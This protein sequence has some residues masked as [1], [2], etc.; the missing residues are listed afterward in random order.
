MSWM[1]LMSLIIFAECATI[2][3][4]EDDAF[5][6]IQPLSED[7]VS[8]QIRDYWVE[9]GKE[10][11]DRITTDSRVPP[12]KLAKNVII[13]V[14]DGMGATTT[15]A[16]RIYKGQRSKELS[17]EEFLLSFD[18][19]PN[20]ALAKTYN[21]DRQVPD[22]AGTAT[23]IFTGV[24][25]RYKMIGLDARNTLGVFDENDYDEGKLSS[26]MSWAQ[27]VKK[28]TGFVT[29][30]RV[31]HATPAATYAHSLHR[32]W[33]CDSKIPEVY[34]GRVKDIAKQLVED[35]PGRHLNVIL[36]G[37]Q[38]ALGY[39]DRLKNETSVCSRLDKTNLTEKWLQLHRNDRV[40]FVTDADGLEN[41]PKDTDHLLGLFSLSH[42]PYKLIKEERGLNVPSLS[43]MTRSALKLLRN[44]EEGFVLMVEG[45]LIDLAHHDNMARLAM[46]EVWDFDNAIAETVASSD[47]D[48]LIIVTSDHSHSF[49]F[50]GYAPRGND[51]MGFGNATLPYL[52]LSYANGPGF[53]YHYDSE[54]N[55]DGFPWKNLTSDRSRLTNPSYMHL[56]SFYLK[57]DTHGGEDVPVY[58]RGPLSHMFAGVIEQSYI[59]HII[60]YAA[61]MGPHAYKNAHCGKPSE[62][63]AATSSRIESNVVLV[64]ILSYVVKNA[65]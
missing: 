50:N 53:D 37:G 40:S 43:A 3:K 32:D 62:L 23:A 65:I 22:S 10:F 9:Q 7:A 63:R 27:S 6:E 5:E 35:E 46:E 2:R 48:T 21:V 14:G 19:F 20:I 34:R 30:T 51:I 11:L 64:I 42:L 45:G 1:M 60:S 49:T 39:R 12:K 33:E 25:S 61:C 58:A 17:G 36:G 52:T 44:S 24:K 41:V 15:T 28:R 8:S 59:A 4:T 54:N 57:E 26:I 29:T 16:A 38:E 47:S 18:K 55:T 31:T 56:A 13:F